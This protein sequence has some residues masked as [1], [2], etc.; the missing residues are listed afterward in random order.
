MDDDRDGVLLVRVWIEGGSD[1]F[2]ARLTSPAASGD[3]RQV[4]TVAVASSP[5]GVARAVHAWLAAFLSG[6]GA[7]TP[8]P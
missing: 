4:F 2:R 5:E 1:Q 8:R 3:P 7:V 6:D